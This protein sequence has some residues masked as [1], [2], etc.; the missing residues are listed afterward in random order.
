MTTLINADTS[1]GLKLTS[2]TSGALDIQSAGSTKLAMDSSGN[3]DIVGT[4]TGAAFEPD[5]DTAA[6]DNAAI[7]YTAAEGLILTGQG[8]TSDVTIKNDAD[9]TVLSIPTGTTKVG[10]GT[11]APDSLVEISSGAATTAKIATTVS[12]N[13]AE[14]ILEDGNAGYGLQVRSDAAQSIATGSMVINDRDTG[15]FPVVINEGNATNTL[16]LKTSRVGIGI[17]APATTL[18]VK[19]PTGTG[20]DQY[21][22][23]VENAKTDNGTAT[24]GLRVKYTSVSP[25]DSNHM[26]QC[27]DSGG[28]V[29]FFVQNNGTRGG[30]SDR[31]L[32]ENIVDATD[33][34]AELRQLQV[35]NYN[36]IDHGPE[37]GFKE[38]GFI[39]Q[40]VEAVFPKMV[41]ENPE[42]G[43]KMLLDDVFVPI[44][45]KSL[46]EAADKI[47]ALETRIA[48]LEA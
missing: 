33:K 38:L 45:V 25:S 18:H 20:A 27:L 4:V 5:G 36:W 46:Q 10:I 16:V 17:A 22:G 21:A 37:G 43:K 28:T 39:A 47:D 8:S 2:D 1:G 42:T 24:T 44:L 23:T 29:R 7:G 11:T 34:L 26:F 19:S 15:S 3:V 12:N 40:E 13:Y 9:A 31:T 35:R 32:K 14:L 6:G 48:A 30:T 41:R